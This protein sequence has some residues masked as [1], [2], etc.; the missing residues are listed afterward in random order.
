MITKHAKDAV[1][2][3]KQPGNLS[4]TVGVIS[5]GLLGGKLGLHWG[6]KAS[7]AAF[8][9]ANKK[10]STKALNKYVKSRVSDKAS[11]LATNAVKSGR[12]RGLL[13]SAHIISRAAK[14]ALP[15]AGGLGGAAILGRIGQRLG[16]TEAQKKQDAMADRAAW[17]Y[18]RKD[19]N[20]WKQYRKDKNK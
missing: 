16:N 15:I 7:R 17:E 19:K 9:D 10:M 4:G 8:N 5:G 2:K 11:P 14:I 6:N 18:Y 13:D 1:K 20:A 12:V 3:T